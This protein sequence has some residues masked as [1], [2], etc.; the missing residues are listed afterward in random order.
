MRVARSCLS[1]CWQ[2][3]GGVAEDL[4][5]LLGRQDLKVGD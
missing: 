1:G 4:L 3:S 5:L 2:A